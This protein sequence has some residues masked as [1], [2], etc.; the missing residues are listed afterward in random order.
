MIYE[1]KREKAINELDVIVAKLSYRNLNK[2]LGFG[3]CLAFNESVGD[4]F[5][6]KEFK[7]AESSRVNN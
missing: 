1:T 6:K 7:N 3:S 5:V 4:D 2:L